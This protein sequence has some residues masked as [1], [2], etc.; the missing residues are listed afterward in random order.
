MNKQETAE[1]AAERFVRNDPDFEVEG[2][3]EYQNGVLNGFVDGAKWQAER[4][5]SEEDMRKCWN[6]SS[7]YTIGS[8]KEFKQIHPNFKDW[9]EQFKKK[10]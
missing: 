6:A 7:A 8:Y 10:V 9:L 3:S 5:Y 2:F 1:E 4:M